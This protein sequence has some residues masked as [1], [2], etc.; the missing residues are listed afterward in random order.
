MLTC[1]FLLLTDK[2]CLGLLGGGEICSLSVNAKFIRI[3]ISGLLLTVESCVRGSLSLVVLGICS[4]LLG[5]SGNGGLDDITGSLYILSEPHEAW[6]EGMDTY[7]SLKFSLSALNFD[8]F[9]K[10]FVS[11]FSSSGSLDL[12]N[13]DITIESGLASCKCC[14]SP[15]FLTVT[16]GLLDCGLSVDLGNVPATLY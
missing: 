1:S 8:I 16:F 2:S 6:W 7:E 3:G 12:G 4:L 10:F 9:S 14:F 5:F 15:G 13:V 11:C